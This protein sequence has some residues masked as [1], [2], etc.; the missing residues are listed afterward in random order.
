MGEPT[1]LQSFP[2]HT[3]HHTSSASCPLSERTVGVVARNDALSSPGYNLFSKGKETY[4]IDHDG[5]VCHQWRAVRGVFVAYLLEDGTLLRDGSENVEAELFQAGG[6]AGYVEL[7]SWD[8]VTLW[9]WSAPR[10]RSHL[11]H[12]DLEPLPGGGCLVMCW[13]RRT[14]EECLAMGRSRELLPDGELWDD[15]I[16]ELQP[17]GKGGAHVTWSWKMWDHLCQ[18]HDPK[19]PNYVTSARE[20]PHRFDIN[21]CPVGGKQG[22]R[23]RTTVA[24]TTKPVEAHNT[25]GATGE[26][27]WVHA[28][29]VSYSAR[30]DAVLIGLCSPSEVLAVGRRS[31]DILWRFGNPSN[32]GGGSRFDQRLFCPHAAHFLADVEARGGGGG[33]GREGTE[34]GGDRV[35]LFNNGRRPDRH[36]SSVDELHVSLPSASEAAAREAPPRVSTTAKLAWTYEPPAG[37]RGSFYCTHISGVQ[38]VPNGNTLVAMGPQGIAFE[39]TPRGEEVFRYVCPA[40]SSK[41]SWGGAA[42]TFVRQGEQRPPESRGSSASLFCFRRYP[43]S[44]GAFAGRILVPGRHLE[45]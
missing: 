25:P 11:T 44:C 28:N 34:G 30:H 41:E 20:A 9:S 4:L 31:G 6:A 36:W 5:R 24:M 2:L 42:V 39:V 23:D 17:D 32:W 26:K 12:H 43:P 21:A 19:L 18:D 15:Q 37:R 3:A 8:N 1:H 35:L 38:R 27:D 33:G 14:K 29:T 16:L 45:G 40:L 10:I 13:Q 22:A 7:V